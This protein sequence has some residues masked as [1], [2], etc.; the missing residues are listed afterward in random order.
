MP[1]RN[2]ASTVG[3]AVRSILRQSFRDWELILIDDGSTDDTLARLRRITDS[4]IRLLHDGQSL[5]LPRRLNEAI[6]QARAPFFARMDGDDVSYP[7]R[8]EAQ[9]AY[10]ESHP[11]ADLAGG[12]L[13]VFGDG[14]R[15]LGTRR[16]PERHADIVKRPHAGFAMAHP[17]F[18][19]RTAWFR[20]W[21]FEPAAG[22]AC[23]Q[24]L[25]LRAHATSRFGN[26][27]DIVLGYREAA[28]VWQKIAG[29]RMKFARAL[30]R[31]YHVRNPYRLSIGVS[32]IAAKLAVDA[33]AVSTGTEHRLLRHR[34]RP[35][36]S[37][38]V[39][40]WAEVWRQCEP[41]A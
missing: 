36:A 39:S 20:T 15:V 27:P 40:E 18:F 19:G 10:L 28:V 11:D 22:G 3:A 30:A 4:R 25:L 5:G 6:D 26:V 31:H 33:V 41:E 13:L 23:D 35:A 1:V 8:L 7:R 2:A 24:D 14:G 21:R 32:L 29:Y 37:H 9:L 34:A 16:G 12:S 38:E 17:T